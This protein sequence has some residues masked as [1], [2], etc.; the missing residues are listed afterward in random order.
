[1]MTVKMVP[2]FCNLQTKEI[3]LSHVRMS[4]LNASMAIASQNHGNV[5]ALQTAMMPLMKPL[6]VLLTNAW[7]NWN[8]NAI[9]QEDASQ[10]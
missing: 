2:T 3:A 10:R 8:S 5:M 7:K 4:N 6:H 9:I 1:M